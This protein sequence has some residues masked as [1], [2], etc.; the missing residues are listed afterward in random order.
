MTRNTIGRAPGAAVITARLADEVREAQ[1][2]SKYAHGGDRERTLR[3]LRRTRVTPA[4]LTVPCPA[5][6]VAAG[7]ACFG[8]AG[9]PGSGVCLP[10][11]SASLRGGAS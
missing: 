7:D 4:A 10:R 5:H 2:A 6:E 8:I 3:E 1:E 11:V 9:T